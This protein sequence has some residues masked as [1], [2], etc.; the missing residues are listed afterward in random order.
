MVVRAVIGMAAVLTFTASCSSGGGGYG[1]PAP[2]PS[3]ASAAASSSPAATRT[4]SAGVTIS[5]RNGTLVGS[6]DR[7]LYVNTADTA[8]HLICTGSC[9][10]AWPPLLGKPVAGVGVPATKLGTLKRPDGSAQVTYGGHPLYEFSG[11]KL[12]SDTKGKD[13]TDAGGTWEIAAAASA[14]APHSAAPSSSSA[15]YGY[16]R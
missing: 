3:S 13:I 11:D 1:A 12:A 9:L 7:T 6:D 16:G 5:L 14:A 2:A 10:S 8:S 15:G 4:A